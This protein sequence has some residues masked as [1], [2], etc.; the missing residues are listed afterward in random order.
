MENT[1]VL[2][3]LESLEHKGKL[4]SKELGQILNVSDRTVRNYMKEI[5]LILEENGAHIFSKPS[6]GYEIEIY[7]SCK[8]QVWKKKLIDLSMLPES[9]DDRIQYILEYLL[10]NKD[11]NIS[12][13]EFSEKLF[14]SKTT[15][16]SDIK[17][18]K[19]ILKQ[20]DYH[21]LQS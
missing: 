7:E 12:A 17:S 18:V 13:E 1:K 9:S 4:T 16:L 14:V 2:T 10:V 21:F 8:Y 3:L 19:N 20:Y 5:S 15:I 11:E 6:K